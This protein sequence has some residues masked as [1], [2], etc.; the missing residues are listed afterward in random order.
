MPVTEKLTPTVGVT[1]IVLPAWPLLHRYDTAPV[2]IMVTC[3]PAQITPGVEVVTTSGRVSAVTVEIAGCADTQPSELV[4]ETE[5]VDVLAGETTVEP[6]D[7]V[8][9]KAPVGT[10]V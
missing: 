10:M 3:S 7:T 6:P 9:D 1:T 5:Y 8:Y 4:P 2:A